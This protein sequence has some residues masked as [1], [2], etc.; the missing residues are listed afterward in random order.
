[1]AILACLRRRTFPCL[2]ESEPPGGIER[3]IMAHRK[4]V[5]AKA[6]ASNLHVFKSVA[7]LRHFESWLTCARLRSITKL[8]RAS[9]IREPRDFQK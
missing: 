1:M 8:L 6:T 7:A 9:G 4:G 2:A 3:L 5:K